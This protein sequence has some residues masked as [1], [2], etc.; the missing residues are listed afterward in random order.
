V[1]LSSGASKSG[2]QHLK[3][4]ICGSEGIG[5]TIF[6]KNINEGKLSN[7][8]VKTIGVDFGKKL[9]GFER[10]RSVMME[11]WDSGGDPKFFSIIR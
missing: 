2:A 4:L 9:M 8:T 11:I 7:T 6:F 10:S 3:L 5:K 1:K